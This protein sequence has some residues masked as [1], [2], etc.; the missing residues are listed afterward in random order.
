MNSWREIEYTPIY[1]WVLETSIS[2]NRPYQKTAIHR[3]R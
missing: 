2:V 1:D 3:L